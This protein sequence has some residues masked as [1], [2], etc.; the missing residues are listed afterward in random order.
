MFHVAHTENPGTPMETVGQRL[1]KIRLACGD[2]VRKPESLDDFATR[3]F[4]AT[5]TRYSAMK[6]SQLERDE[7]KWRIEDVS[8]LARVD[9]HKRGEEWLAFGRSLPT[10]GGERRSDGGENR[11]RG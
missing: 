5:K 1:F 2:G 3:V 8:T 7:Q 10:T 11:K 6:L 9:P 4:R